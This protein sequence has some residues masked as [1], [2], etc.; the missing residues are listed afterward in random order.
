MS[1]GKRSRSVVA[2]AVQDFAPDCF[3]AVRERRPRTVERET[4][5]LPVQLFGDYVFQITHPYFDV[6]QRAKRTRNG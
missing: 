1:V 6:D 5:L 4:E 2:V 3:G